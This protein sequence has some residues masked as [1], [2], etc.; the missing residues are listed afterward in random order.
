MVGAL[1]IDPHVKYGKTHH[2]CDVSCHY[3]KTGVKHLLCSGA[4]DQNSKM[5]DLAGQKCSGAADQNSKMADLAGQK[6]F[7]VLRSSQQGIG[8][9]CEGP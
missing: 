1:A 9:G 4:A 8:S 7:G 6:W 5:A 2:F 3:C